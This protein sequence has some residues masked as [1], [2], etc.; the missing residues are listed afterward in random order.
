[1][2]AAQLKLTNSTQT[3]IIDADLLEFLSQWNWRLGSHG[4]ACRA[5]RIDGVFRQILLHRVIN[6]TPEGK[7]TDHINGSRLDDRRINLRTVTCAQ[8]GHNRNGRKSR[9]KYKGVEVRPDGKHWKA[10]IRANGSRRYLGFFT[11]E[12]EAAVAYDRAA[13]LLHGEFA[14]LNFPVP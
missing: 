7:H 2:D 11:S 1:M 3:A 6:G 10:E 14:K 12:K 8:N 13:I 5:E 9:S 4:Y